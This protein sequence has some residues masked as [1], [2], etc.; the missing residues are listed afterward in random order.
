MSASE[1][2]WLQASGNYVN[3]HVRGRAYPLRSTMAAIEPQLDPARFVRVHRSHAVNLD[4]IAEIEPLDS[5][6][7]RLVMKDGS[8]VP[9]SRRYRDGLAPRAG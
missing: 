2:E 7:A 1:V 6:D 4:H 9:C 5:G 3:L 8:S